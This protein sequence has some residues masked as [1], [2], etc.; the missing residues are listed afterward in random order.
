MSPSQCE[1]SLDV[2]FVF[3]ARIAFPGEL[4]FEAKLST[5]SYGAN[6]A[7]IGHSTSKDGR[8]ILLGGLSNSGETAAGSRS[9]NV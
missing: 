3:G 6:D 4:A 9:R 5:F 2:G 8:L 7:D 1:K